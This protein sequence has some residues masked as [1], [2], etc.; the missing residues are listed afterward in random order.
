MVMRGPRLEFAVGTFL[1]LTLA[2]LL[3][4]AVASTNQRWSMGGNQYTLTAHFTQIG[5]L[6]KQA[7]VRISGVNIG[8]VSNITL[9]PKTFESV[10]TLSLDKQYKDLP[11][12]TS[13]NILTSGLLGESYI[14][15]LPGGDP[16]VLKPG[17]QI[18]F[19][20]PAVDLIQLVGKY[21]FSG[22]SDKS[23]SSNTTSTTDHAASSH[24][25]TQET[26]Q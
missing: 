10:V 4:L 12:D 9:D 8:Q 3:V 1:L 15:L 5:Q 13:A 7:P 16:E 26:H 22:G 17:D 11:A 14:N 20:Q 19:T 21:M 25:D 6:R 23:T 24:T 18:A 2:S